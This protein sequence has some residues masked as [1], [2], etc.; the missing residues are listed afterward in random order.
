MIIIAAPVEQCFKMF[1]DFDRQYLYFPAIT[2][3]KALN[4]SENR[5]V[6]YKE[7]DYRVAVFRYTHI[8]TIDPAR[9]RVD[10][11][12]DPTG[13]NDIK[14]SQGFFQFEKIDDT[15]ALF[16]YGLVKLDPG[17]KIPEFIQEYMTS[18]D[19]PKMAINLKKYI[20]SGGKWKK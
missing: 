16:T 11:V 6:I 19:L 12:T 14:F 15:R 1:C 2:N 5:V 10:F 18:R 9:R 13:V 17:I 3:S 4:R 20:E 8:L 7:L